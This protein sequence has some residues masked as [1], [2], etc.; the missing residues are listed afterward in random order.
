MPILPLIFSNGIWMREEQAVSKGRCARKAWDVKQS[1]AAKNT[2]IPVKLK[3]RTIS[4]RIIENARP[5]SANVS[6]NRTN[7]NNRTSCNSLNNLRDVNCGKAAIPT[8]TATRSMR[9]P[10]PRSGSA[11]R[12]R[13]AKAQPGGN[14]VMS[15]GEPGIASSVLPRSEP[16]TVE[17]SSPWV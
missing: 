9:R 17:D 7:F 5:K 2:T 14:R 11:K 4:S 3:K 1:D 8:T 15:G 12:Q 16:W 13:G 10:A 6:L